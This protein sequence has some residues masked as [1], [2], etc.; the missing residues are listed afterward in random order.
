VAFFVLSDERKVSTGESR[1]KTLMKN[2]DLNSMSIEALWALHEEIASMLATKM[3]AERLKLKK[4]LEQITGKTSDEAP[5]RRP[6]PKVHPMFRNPD[7]PHQTWSGRGKQP[8]W[9]GKALA[10]GRTV[11]DLR[12]LSRSPIEGCEN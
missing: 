4:R 8:K 2:I 10:E 3:E 12:I 1:V 6:Y 7:P 5:K 11:D 9:M